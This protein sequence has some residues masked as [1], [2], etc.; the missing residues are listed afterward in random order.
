MKCPLCNKPANERSLCQRCESRLRIRISEITFLRDESKKYIQAQQGGHGTNSG[1]PTI[2]INVAALDFS[3]GNDILPIMWEWEKVIREDRKLTPPALVEPQP[4][5][6]AA[7]VE[8]HLA[9]LEWSFEQGWVDEYARE[10]ATIHT[11]G[12]HAAR[13]NVEPVRRISCPSPHPEDE[14]RYC[15]AM[16]AV[17][18]ADLL[19]PIMCKRCGTQWTP[20]R[21]VAVAMSDPDREVWLD[22]ESIGRWVGISDRQVR[23]VCR[24][25]RVSK[26]GQLYNVTEFLAA[27]LHH[28]E[29][30]K[31]A[32]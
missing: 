16:L 12:T 29:Q 9:H 19:A 7:T 27:R 20:A 23:R 4:D 32:I 2:G 13:R 31:K 28:V 1:E 14:A 5:E 24:A 10:I 18:D 11:K 6:V 21:L 3:S 26:R 17:D 15:N 8:F 25:G 22:A 30:I